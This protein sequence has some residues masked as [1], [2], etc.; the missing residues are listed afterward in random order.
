MSAVPS[1]CDLSCI[2]DMS[3]I[4]LLTIICEKHV[5]CVCLMMKK[6]FNIFYSHTR[7]IFLQRIY[8]IF[9]ILWGKLRIWCYRYGTIYFC[10]NYSS[11]FP[12]SESIFHSFWS[13]NSFMPIQN[14]PKIILITCKNNGT[15]GA[16]CWK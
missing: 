9:L 5:I 2:L 7:N 13:M 4:L 10:Q 3:R 6:M 15:W 8:L 12:E 1:C 16:F 14:Q 11:Y